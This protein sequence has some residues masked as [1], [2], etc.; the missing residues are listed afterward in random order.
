MGLSGKEWLMDDIR[1]ERNRL[2]KEVE[3]LKQ[4]MRLRIKTDDEARAQLGDVICQSNGLA[5]A[6]VVVRWEPGWDTIELGGG[7]QYTLLDLEAIVYW[8]RTYGEE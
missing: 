3:A 2:K 1:N 5:A 6:E 4:E 8:M 7:C